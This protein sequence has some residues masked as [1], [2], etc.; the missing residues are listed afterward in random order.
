MH[1]FTA[2][3]FNQPIGN[4]NTGKVT[5][6]QNMFTYA[7]AFNQDIGNWNTGKVTDMSTCFSL[8]LR[9]IRISGAGTRAR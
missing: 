7:T 9:S 4:W 5:N 2:T 8:P 6:M 3:A 1:M